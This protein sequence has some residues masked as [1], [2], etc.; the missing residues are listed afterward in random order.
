M[1]KNLVLGL[2]FAHLAQI[3]AA[4]FF[5]FFFFQKSY[6]NIHKILWSATTMYI[7]RKN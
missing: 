2:I 1:A 7:I 5:F 6:F 3:W 4:N